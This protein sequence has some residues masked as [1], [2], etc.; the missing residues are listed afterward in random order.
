MRAKQLAMQREI[1][2]LRAEL[3]RRDRA[4]HRELAALRMELDAVRAELP[5][6][7]KVLSG[8]VT[9]PQLSPSAIKVPVPVAPKQPAASSTPAANFSS[10]PTTI[11]NLIEPKR[12]ADN[13]TSTPKPT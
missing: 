2:D 8:T 4:M 12:P 10:A 6:K 9:L 13:G 11:V 5:N 7:A 1:Y 3:Q